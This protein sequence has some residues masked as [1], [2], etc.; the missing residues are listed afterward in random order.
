MLL[1]LKLTEYSSFHWLKFSVCWA[2]ACNFT[3]GVQM[4]VELKRNLIL[5]LTLNRIKQNIVL[6]LAAWFPMRQE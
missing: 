2:L 3:N 1:I 4:R 6:M 5:Q